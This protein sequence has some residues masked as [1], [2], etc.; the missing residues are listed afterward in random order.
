VVPAFQLERQCAGGRHDCREVNV[1]LMPH[2]KDE[3]IDLMVAH[4]ANPF[5]PYNQ[6]GHGSTRYKDWLVQ[7][8]DELIP[9][10]CVNSNRYEPYLA[11]RYC[12]DLP[13]FQE[14]FTG[15]GKNKMTWLMQL[16]RTGYQLLQLGGAFVVHYPHLESTARMHWNGGKDGEQLRK[17]NDPQVDLSAFKRGQ[18]DQ[19]FVNF[20]NWLAQNIPDEAVLPQCKDALNDDERLWIGNDRQ[21]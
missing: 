14:A 1:P 12:H 13:P 21:K 8:D 20:R 5:D 6:G 11:F 7:Q 9:I 4:K 18:I 19:T 2:S 3:L 15:Y 16:R 10:D 17:P